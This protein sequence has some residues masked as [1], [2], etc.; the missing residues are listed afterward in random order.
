MAGLSASTG[1]APVPLTRTGTP[2]NGFALFLVGAGSVSAWK[3]FSKIGS[4]F[5]P[6]AVGVPAIERRCAGLCSWPPAAVVWLAP[7]PL[8]DP[9]PA[10]GGEAAC[11]P[12]AP[13]TVED[14][15]PACV[16]KAP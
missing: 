1:A 12:G 3:W 10:G 14:R 9:A 4:E 16:W 7:A 8:E 13:A 5:A 15:A 2:A 6:G 11:P